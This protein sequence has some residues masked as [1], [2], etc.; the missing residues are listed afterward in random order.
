MSDEIPFRFIR[1]Q[2]HRHSVFDIVNDEFLSSHECAKRLNNCMRA[3]GKKDD[4][5]ERLATENEQLKQKI[6]ELEEVNTQLCDFNLHNMLDKKNKEINQLKKELRVW[7]DTA[8]SLECQLA[9]KI[10]EVLSDD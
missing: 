7:K 9:H 5:I 4:E 10:D 6:T 2:N 1:Y 8:E 3:I